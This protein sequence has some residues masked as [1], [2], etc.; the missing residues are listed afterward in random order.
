MPKGRIKHVFP[1]GNTSLGFYSYYEYILSQE[2]ATRIIVIKGGPGVGKSTFMKKT[3]ADM[4]DRGYDIELMHCSSD[5]NSLDGVVI[6]EIKVALLDGTAP[7]VVDPKNPGAV[8]EILHLGDFW[9]EDGI[10]KNREEILK[11]NK[12]VGRTFARAYRYIKAAAA[13]YEDTAVIN[14]WAMDNAKANAEASRVIGDLFVD[15]GLA[16]KEGKVRKL[17]ASAITPDGF[18]NY[19]DTILTADKIYVLKGQQGTGTE[20]L[21]EKVKQAA[22]ERGSNVEAYY[23]ALIPTKLEHLVVPDMKLAFTTFNDYHNTEV[24]AF[25]EIDFDEF[26]DPQ[27]LKEYQ[28]VLD[29]NRCTFKALMNRAVSTIN[30]AKAIHDIMEQYYIPNMDFEAVQRCWESTM[31]RIFEY[32]QEN[33]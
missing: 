17:F 4:A 1:G 25:E 8:D 13:V 26:M 9:D 18:K 19:L 24:E 16:V 31:A 20:K 33:T 5:N 27:V 15:R 21:L 10:R 22:L 3:A 32:A 28:E 11:C 23:C 2:E 12:E 29:Y 7:H 30:K 6:P 14:S